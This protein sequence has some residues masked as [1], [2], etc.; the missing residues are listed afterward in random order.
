MDSAPPYKYIMMVSFTVRYMT[1]LMPAAY[2]S[3]SSVT[4]RRAR[5]KEPGST[6]CVTVG[7]NATKVG[8]R[9]ITV[10]PDLLTTHTTVSKL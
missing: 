6:K 4:A 5:V 8:L 10:Q 1:V 7:S 9:L 3:A 2:T